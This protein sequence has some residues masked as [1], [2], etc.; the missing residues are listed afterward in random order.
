M[1][2]QLE[3]RPSMVC[4]PRSLTVSEISTCHIKITKLAIFS[5]NLTYD[6]EIN[7][8]NYVVALLLYKC[9]IDTKFEEPTHCSYRV[10]LWTKY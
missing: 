9:N 2:I 10:M 6:L 4:F 3:P 1:K 7:S 8:P 5:K